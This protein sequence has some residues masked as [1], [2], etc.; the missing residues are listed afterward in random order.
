MNQSWIKTPDGVTRALGLIP[1]KIYGATLLAT[2]P[3]S[4]AVIVPASEL[5]AFDAWPRELPIL[6][7]GQWNACTY[8][9]S[10]Q[11][12]SYARYESGQP[13]VALD[14]LYPY[15]KVTGGR[16]TGTNILQAA[17]VLAMGGVPPVNMARSTGVTAAALRFRIELSESLTTWEELLSAVARR[18]PVVG[19]VYVGMSY[20][21]LDAEGA[22]GVNRGQANHAIFLGGGLKHSKVHGWMVKHAGSWGTAWGQGGFGWYT[23]AHFD[24]AGYGEAYTVQAACEDLADNENPPPVIG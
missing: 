20:H 1:S 21:Y 18:R 11:A 19:S 14:P 17:Q 15:L 8:F 6:D 13:Y 2:A 7:Q 23:Q 9:S 12:L 10:V 16:N 4:G 22:M 3:P 5:V 24:N